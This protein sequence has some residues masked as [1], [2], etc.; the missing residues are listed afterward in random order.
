MK[1][2]GQQEEP[3]FN[4]YNRH[5]QCIKP[6]KKP[7]LHFILSLH[8]KWSKHLQDC[9]RFC[10]DIDTLCL[11][12]AKGL[13]VWAVRCGKIKILNRNEKWQQKD[14]EHWDVLV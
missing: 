6:W 7:K 11:H 13:S 4:I 12:K 2:I 14:Q 9:I 3:D 1:V 5:I 10:K 8:L